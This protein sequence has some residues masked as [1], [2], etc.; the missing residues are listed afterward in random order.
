MVRQAAST[1]CW[2]FLPIQLNF[3]YQPLC[4]DVHD[5]DRDPSYVL[6]IS[7]SLII[8][9]FQNWIRA[10]NKKDCRKTSWCQEQVQSLKNI[11]DD[12]GARV[13]LQTDI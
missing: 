9:R 7:H 12:L 13:K 11:C 5:R 6:N 1:P 4:T 10:E 2:F 8:R 3:N